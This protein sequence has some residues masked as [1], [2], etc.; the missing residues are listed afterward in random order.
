MVWYGQYSA[1]IASQKRFS[2]RK[3]FTWSGAVRSGVVRRGSVWQRGVWRAREKS[4]AIAPLLFLQY[5]AR[6]C[7]STPK[8][9]QTMAEP[10][11]H[12]VYIKHIDSKIA[13]TVSC[14]LV[15]ILLSLVALIVQ[16]TPAFIRWE[17]RISLVKDGAFDAE[18]RRHGEHGWE[19]VF[20]R[21]AAEGQI[22]ENTQYSY[23]M[24]F[25]RQK[26]WLP[27]VNK[28]EP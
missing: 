28:P 9:E 12:P 23:E 6:R 19:L 22:S 18:M 2:E 10:K 15:A 27:F 14:L 1:G 25:R 5:A 8:P 3:C 11:P 17:Y 26:S 16:Q 7:A 4:G 21:R 24:I 13:A 20:A